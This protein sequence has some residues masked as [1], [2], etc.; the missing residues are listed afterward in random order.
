MKGILMSP[1][2]VRITDEFLHVFTLE[3]QTKAQAIKIVNMWLENSDST[4][5]Q[6]I[7]IEIN[8]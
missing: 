8:E 7:V 4:P 6:E 3:A 1:Y 5:I 2:V